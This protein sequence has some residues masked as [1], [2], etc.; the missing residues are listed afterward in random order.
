M[1]WDFLRKEC[2]GSVPVLKSHVCV[3]VGRVVIWQALPLTGRLGE[4]VAFLHLKQTLISAVGP[5]G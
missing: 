2:L 3:G 5:Q 4:G 1:Y